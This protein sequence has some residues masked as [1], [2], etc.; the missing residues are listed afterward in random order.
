MDPISFEPA[1][2]VT[3]EHLQ[4]AAVQI[5][6]AEFAAR[7]NLQVRRDMLTDSLLYRLTSSV[8]AEHLPPNVVTETHVWTFEV[9]ASPWQ[10]FK[11]QHATA[12][13]LAWLV[14]R[15][16]VRMSSYHR[17]GELT[18]TLDKYWSWPKARI[19]TPDWG[20][21]VRVAVVTPRPVWD[22]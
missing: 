19:M 3:L 20:S 1:E 4:F 6:S 10:A 7:M 21:P 5:V 18:V 15:R 13:W 11:D 22:R 8:L 17:R 16:P 12:W 2:T 9:P 14:R